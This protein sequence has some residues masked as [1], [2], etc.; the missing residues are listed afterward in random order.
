[1]IMKKYFAEVNVSPCETVSKM[2]YKV[3]SCILIKVKGI[4]STSCSKG[5]I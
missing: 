2:D 5:K 3:Y 1:M 4:I